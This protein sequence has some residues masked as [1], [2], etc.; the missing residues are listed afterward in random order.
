MAVDTELLSA[1][2]DA[3]SRHRAAAFEAPHARWGRFL[4]GLLRVPVQRRRREGPVSPRRLVDPADWPRFE[5]RTLAWLCDP[6]GE[7]HLETRGL[8]VV[9][10]LVG[11][12]LGEPVGRVRISV[13]DIGV[14][15]A[16]GGRGWVLGVQSAVGGLSESG[17]AGYGVE[18]VLVVPR[19][20]LAR[21][22]SVLAT[23]AAPESRWL[24]AGWAQSLKLPRTASEEADP[25]ATIDTFSPDVNFLLDHWREYQ[26]LLAVRGRLEAEFASLRER[27][28]AAVSA[29]W[30]PEDGWVATLDEDWILLRRAS[31]PVPAEEWLAFVVVM[32]DMEALLTDG[33]DGWF[34]ALSMPTDGDFDDDAFTALLR[35]R[36][37]PQRFGEL[38]GTRWPGYA[39]AR[40]LPR[41]LPG[42]SM[43]TEVERLAVAEFERLVALT[44]MVDEVLRDLR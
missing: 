26:E 5:A 23:E 10:G 16:V 30:R 9:L 40:Q 19:Q 4:E 7:H 14:G 15:V 6:E 2:L 1:L 12:A 24:L 42:P 37:D 41:V 17:S 11:V 3:F 28:F 39:L 33:R 44:P 8:A 43:I 29:R 32:T 27:V 36:L 20:A 38:L 21:E 25:M 22:L 13:D 35:S 31:W 34:A 18:G